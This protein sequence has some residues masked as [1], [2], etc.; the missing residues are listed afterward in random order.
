MLTPDQRHTLLMADRSRDGA[1]VR[2]A[3]VKVMAD[4]PKASLLDIEMAFR[5]AAA[6]SYLVAGPDKLMIYGSMPEALKA[7][8]DA[9]IGPGGNWV[10]LI[11]AT[12]A[13]R[14]D[15]GTDRT[16]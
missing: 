11:Q 9:G 15:N 6:H 10:A 12:A 16:V 3:I 8:R 13:V 1:T 4:N 7:L 14:H 5:D 2:Q